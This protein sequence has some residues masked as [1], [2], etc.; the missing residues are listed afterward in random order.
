MNRPRWMT[1]I[2]VLTIILGLW[3]VVNQ[4]ITI[5]S[6]SYY[7]S[8]ESEMKAASLITGEQRPNTR[9]TPH[10][11]EEPPTDE[12]TLKKKPTYPDQSLDNLRP[13]YNEHIFRTIGIGVISLLISG[14]YLLAGLFLMTKS[15]GIRI[16][17]YIMAA[18][19]LWAVVQTI[20]VSQAQLEMF[21]LFMTM[22]MP[23]IVIDGVLC[24][25]IFLGSRYQPQGHSN[26]T[27]RN[28]FADAAS[29]FRNPVNVG[30]PVLTGA[31]AL[32]CI[33]V[34]PF[35]IMG[36]PGVSNAYARGWNIGLDV[37]MYYPLAWI[38]GYGLFRLL[39][40]YLHATRH[41]S[42][43][44][45]VAICLSLLCALSIVRLIQAFRIMAM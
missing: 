15:Y 5:V 34:L 25:G 40:K 2:G 28:L 22:K 29:I 6:S 14:A 39:K 36:I 32:L 20:L 30:I 44:V 26:S 4:T 7:L 37:I 11:T 1:I 23:S 21:V 31:F 24:A 13:R 9:S 8:M 27:D 10:S 43:D 45:G 19:V 17:Y 38:V 18:S 12:T 33:F 35:W 3:G 42:V 16:F 41:Q